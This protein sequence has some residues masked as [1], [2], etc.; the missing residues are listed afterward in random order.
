MIDAYVWDT[1]NG[2]KLTIALEESGLLYTRHLVN[3]GTGQQNLPEFRKVNPNGKIPAIVDQN[4]P[5]G[6]PLAMFESGAIL[7]YLAEKSGQLLPT[8]VRGRWMATQW[9]MFQMAGVGP[10]FGQ[11]GFFLRAKEKVPLA[12][13]RYVDESN[14]LLGVLDARLGEVEYLAGEYSVADIAT[15]PWIQGAVHY[16]GL[17]LPANV[18]RWSDAIAARP[19]VQRGMA[20]AKG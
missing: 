17:S 4:G 5:D 7:L 11:A 20:A 9:L 14:R 1:P 12:I 2:Q 6:T 3:L 18:A 10:M 8:D 19:A 16:L 15:W 13:D